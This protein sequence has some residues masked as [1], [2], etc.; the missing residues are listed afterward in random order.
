MTFLLLLIGDDF[1]LS[2]DLYHD[3]GFHNENAFVHDDFY[4]NDNDDFDF[5]GDDDCNCSAVALHGL[6]SV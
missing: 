4:N 3:A 2:D 1:D 5:D 6:P